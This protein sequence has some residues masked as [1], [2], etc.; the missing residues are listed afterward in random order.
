MSISENQQ[1]ESYL[2]VYDVVPEK[3]EEA[4]ELLLEYLKKVSFAVN[5]REIGFFL[6]EELLSGKALFPG[7]STP[8]S[9]AFRTMLRKV[10]DFGALPNSTTKSIAHGIAIDSNFRI[11]QMY[12]GASDTTGLTGFGCSYWSK[13]LSAAINLNYDVTNVNVTTTQDYSN[14][15]QCLVVLE[16]TSES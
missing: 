8:N 9:Q 10:I 6:D 15:N 4:R 14:F 1:F 16:Y 7:V 5:A 11:V 3:W 2:P 12:L 13:N